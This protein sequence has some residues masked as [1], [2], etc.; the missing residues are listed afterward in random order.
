MIADWNIWKIAKL[1][2]VFFCRFRVKWAVN[3]HTWKQ[4][5]IGLVC[6]C[7]P[8]LSLLECDEETSTQ[9][10]DR[11]THLDIKDMQVPEVFPLSKL[12]DDKLSDPGDFIYNYTGSERKTEVLPVFSC[13][14]QTC[15]VRRTP[16][17]L[18]H[19]EPIVSQTSLR[20]QEWRTGGECQT[21]RKDEG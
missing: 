20:Q 7:H 6:M 11:R 9:C 21:V 17:K 18:H 12:W 10:P 15:V 1:I 19:N 5:T 13:A 16:M 3:P 8:A 14:L 2:Y 4:C